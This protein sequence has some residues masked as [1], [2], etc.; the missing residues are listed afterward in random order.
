MAW[1]I[2]LVIIVLQ[3]NEVVM[4]KSSIVKKIVRGDNVRKTRFHSSSGAMVS[5][6]NLVGIFPSIASWL[7]HRLTG[8]RYQLPWWTWEAIHICREKLNIE[9]RVL[10]IGSGVSTIWLAKRSAHVDAIEQDETWAAE[11][12]NI[13]NRSGCDNI[14]LH[15]GN[16]ATL[17]EKLLASGYKWE[18]A[19]VDGTSDRLNIFSR[20]LSDMPSLQMIIFDDTDR[21]EYRDA[22]TW[23]SENGYKAFRFIGFKPQ[24]LHAC[25]TTIFLR[26]EQ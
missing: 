15:Q 11:V 17:L 9:D 24:T 19:V 5:A 18:V 3:N 12:N 4:E 6:S 7:M 25:E 21:P 26:S 23:A 2:E 14:I 13:A 10:E 1:Q 22:F 8:K 16:E 20:L